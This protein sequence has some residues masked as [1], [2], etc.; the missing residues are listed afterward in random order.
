[1]KL[2][3]IAILVAGVTVFTWSSCSSE[4]GKASVEVMK[5][6]MEDKLVELV[7]KGEVA[8]QMHRTRHA[9]I[10]TGLVRIKATLSGTKRK[11]AEKKTQLETLEIEEARSTVET[12][13]A[14]Y[15]AHIVKLET[16]EQKAISALKSSVIGYE[17][18]KLK[19][20]LLEEQIDLARTMTS[21]E[22]SINFD[23][24]SAAVNSII[25]EMNRDLDLA[26]ATLAVQALDLNL[27]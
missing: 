25:E 11:L 6:R 1:M 26:E 16:A 10:K 14:T 13:A 8:L 15:E 12:L 7:G 20:T 3:L 4:K 22:S 19:V 27:Q 21:V 23:D 17:K 2:I 24:T 9:K 5:K 18:L